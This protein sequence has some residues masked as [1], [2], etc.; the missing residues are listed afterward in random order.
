MNLFNINGEYLSIVNRL[1][2]CEGELTPELENDIEINEAEFEQKAPAYG[3]VI[4]GKEYNIDMI[5]KEIERL[6]GYITKE[7]RDKDRL[8]K[9]LIM[10]MQIRGITKIETVN[11]KISLKESKSVEI[12]NEAQLSEEF[13]RTYVPEPTRSPNKIA[14]KKAIDEGREVEGAVLIINKSI[15]IK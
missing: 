13:I 6:K 10:S 5:K 12:I 7:E 2:E 1:T 8:K 3:H 9:A 14:I 11:M 4:I 15:Q